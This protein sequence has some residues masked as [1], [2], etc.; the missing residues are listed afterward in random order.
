[1]TNLAAPPENDVLSKTPESNPMGSESPPLGMALAT[2][3]CAGFALAGWLI[4]GGPL[5]VG[6]FVLAYIAGGIAATF[7]AIASLLRLRL[8]IDL[9]MILA[10]IGAAILGDWVEGAILLFL[11]SLSNTLEAYALYRTTRSIDAL[12]QLRPREASL[13]RDGERVSGADRGPAARRRGAGPARRAVP[14]RR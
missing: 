9:L 13:V 6:L 8:S 3:L 12:I 10:A 5:S 11:F 4:G 7:V 14:G 2:L 1:M